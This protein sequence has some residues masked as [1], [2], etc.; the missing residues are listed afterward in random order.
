ME[1]LMRAAQNIK[2]P[3]A[4][5]FGDSGLQHRLLA[6]DL[7]IRDHK[8]PQRR[9]QLQEG[10]EALEGSAKRDLFCRSSAVTRTVLDRAEQ[11]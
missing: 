2:I 5:T 10:T 3:R 11:G 4:K 8:N 7:Q 6:T 9:A 1:D